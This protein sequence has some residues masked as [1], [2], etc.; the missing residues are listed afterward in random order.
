MTNSETNTKINQTLASDETVMEFVQYVQKNGSSIEL[1]RSFGNDVSDYLDKITW[2][3][4][5]DTLA[6]LKEYDQTVRDFLKYLVSSGVK[7]APSAYLNSVAKLELP[8]SIMLFLRGDGS[9][10]FSH[11][12]TLTMY[13]SN[14]VMPEKFAESVVTNHPERLPI[15][16]EIN[17][18]GKQLLQNAA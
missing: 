9:V 15:Y 6:K 4:M 10:W 11:K 2:H 16:A 17:A 14:T 18:Q 7:V 3:N 8:Q 12:E 5:P 13:Y 1:W